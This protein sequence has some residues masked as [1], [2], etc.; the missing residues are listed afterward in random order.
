[1]CMVWEGMHGIA[2]LHSM[3]TAVYTTSLRHITTCTSPSP[4]QQPHPPH[5]PRTF[6]LPSTEDASTPESMFQALS[7]TLLQQSHLCPLPMYS[8]PIRWQLDPSLRLYP[9]PHCVVLADSQPQ[10]QCV[11]ASTLCINPVRVWCLC[12]WLGGWMCVCMNTM[13]CWGCT[14]CC[15]SCFSRRS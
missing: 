10:Q 3:C 15:F 14:K 2:G 1:M 12:G 7:A 13:S 5:L 8:Q 9:L 6:Q 4:P 11:F